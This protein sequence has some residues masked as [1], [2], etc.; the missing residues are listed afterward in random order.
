M[1]ALPLRT[2]FNKREWAIRPVGLH[3]AVQLVN[4]YHYARTGS[5][6]VVYAFGLFLN[7][8]PNVWG[9]SWWIPAAKLSV[10]KF[11]PG[12]YSTTLVLHRLVIHPLVPTNGASFLLGRSIQAITQH[13]RHNTL[14]TYADTA[15]GHT[16]A[17][18]RATN[19]DYEGLSLPSEVWVNASGVQVSR[20]ATGQS[21]T[22]DE[23]RAQGCRFIGYFPK[24]VYS[25]RLQSKTVASKQLPLFAA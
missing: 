8:D 23:L 13:G 14:L 9:V 16:G 22:H 3:I 11:N 12:G 7:G 18:Y 20:Y 1:L 19:W 17:I 15:Q 4:R 21:Y 5:S 10:D 6:A 2:K 25:M 24:H